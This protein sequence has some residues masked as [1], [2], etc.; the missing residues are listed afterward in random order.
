MW[1]AVMDAYEWSC[2]N[3]SISNYQEIPKYV[4]VS[5]IPKNEVVFQ[6]S[7]LQTSHLAVHIV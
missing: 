4:P 3:V 5:A 6:P 1:S 7:G 2:E